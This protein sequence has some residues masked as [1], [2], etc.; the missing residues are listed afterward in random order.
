MPFFYAELLDDRL[1][2]FDVLVDGRRDDSVL[3]GQER[4][5]SGNA[6]YDM[7][8]SFKGTEAP[9]NTPAFVPVSYT[10]DTTINTDKTLEGTATIELQIGRAGERGIAFEL[11][12]FLKVQSAQ[13]ASG[14][15]LDFFQNDTLAQKQL[16]ERGNDVVLVFLPESARAGQT[17]RIRISYRGSVISDAG[18]GVYFVGD[19]G[20]WY[21]HVGGG[22]GQ[23]ATFDTTFRWP[24]KLQLVATGEKV[25][26]H[27]E[28]DQRIGHWRSEGRTPI[29]G[30]NLGDY[31]VQNM[32]AVN[33]IRIQVA[34]NSDL[35]N[36]IVNRMRSQDNRGRRGNNACRDRTGACGLL[37][38]RLSLKSRSCR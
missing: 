13:D 19:R 38:R 21:P 10:V 30:F 15:P 28:G 18:N 35:E 14:T 7:W 32:D 11:S 25:E 2:A 37:Q 8:A 6:Y 20:I 36:A 16:A 26:E 22:M 29:S 1:G 3:I 23:F 34:A 9:V 27:E 5:A 4:W 33:G 12:R 31:S 24:R 17:Y